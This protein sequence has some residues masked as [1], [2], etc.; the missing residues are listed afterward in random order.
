MK[1]QPKV[2]YVRIKFCGCRLLFHIKAWSLWGLCSFFCL[3]KLCVE[4][5]GENVAINTFSYAPSNSAHWQSE[6]I[7]TISDN[8]F[9]LLRKVI[10]NGKLYTNINLGKITCTFEPSSNA[11]AT[12]A[13]THLHHSRKVVHLVTKM[14]PL[15][16]MIV[17]S[18]RLL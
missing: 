12:M 2:G 17:H 18:I 6:F 14:I 4:T 11:V 13:E 5:F 15:H 10:L 7:K 16:P 8:T 9:W 1:S 3:H